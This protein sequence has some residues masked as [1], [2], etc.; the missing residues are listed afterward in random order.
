MTHGLQRDQNG[1]L[2]PGAPV[3]L[4]VGGSLTQGVEVRLDGAATVE[5]IKAGTFLTIQGGR[6]RYFGVVTDIALGSSD[7]RMKHTPPQPGEDFLVQVLSG[8]VAYGA[9]TVM[10]SVTLPSVLGDEESPP[11]AKTIPPHFARAYTAAPRDVELVFGREDENHFWIGNPLDMETKLCLDLD[12]LVQ[13]SIGI[14]G[15]SGTGK[16]FLTRLL[17]VGILQ[18]NRASSIIF[19]M[20]SEYGWSGQD[21]DRRRVVKGLKQL[22]PSQVSTF[23]LDEA[24]SRRRGS[25]VDEVVGISY[26]DVEPEDLLTLRETL[27]LSEVA[28]GAGFNLERK[29][30]PGKWLREFL[31]RQGQDDVKEL[32]EDVGINQQA[33]LTLHRRLSQLTRYEFFT[34]QA[35]KD[36]AVQIIE[37]AEKGRHVALEFGRYG[38]DPTAYVLVSTLLCRRIHKRY[39]DLK[40]QAAGGG[41]R[42]PRP[43]VLV[44]EEAHKFL[45]PAIASQTIFGIIAR[46]LRKYNVTLMVIDQ[47]PA[48]IDSE[49]MSQ[50][51]TLLTCR[52]DNE[53]D[54][55]AVLAGTPGARQLRTVLSRLESRQQALLFGDALPMPV[56]VRTREYGSEG[57]YAE[58]GRKAGLQPDAHQGETAAQR[59]ERE[60]KELF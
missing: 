29:F 35:P 8:I 25:P 21:A 14:F 55:E 44:I 41:G 11:P 37:H 52:L 23:T 33:L 28:A 56:V 32:A 43:L 26:G 34:D 53:K 47:R 60:I 45:S 9:V 3:G 15:K 57:S 31:A 18:R 50:L 6:Q 48:A 42:E 38:N 17:L 54:V 16:T 4:V 59:L 36:A 49:V 27:N 5:D 7:P 19:D 40:E 12:K 10:P 2:L 51:G 39:I 58:L 24:S 1:G 30:G 20:H 13:R 22:F 46:E